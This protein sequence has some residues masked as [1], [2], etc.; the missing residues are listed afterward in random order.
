MIYSAGP[1]LWIGDDEAN[2]DLND[3]ALRHVELPSC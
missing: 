2:L 1:L 3:V